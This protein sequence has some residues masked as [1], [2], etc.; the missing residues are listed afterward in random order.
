MRKIVAILLIQLAMLGSAVPAELEVDDDMMRTIEDTMKSLDSNVAIKDVKA[1]RAEARELAELFARIEAYYARKGDTPD[2]V[3]FARKTH[4]L[5]AQV[6]RAVDSQDFDTA[7]DTVELF[8][9]SCKAC[10]QVYK[11]DK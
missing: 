11:K 7:S 10:Q 5:A 9:K 1:A 3:G 4:D 8:V 2:A 6:L